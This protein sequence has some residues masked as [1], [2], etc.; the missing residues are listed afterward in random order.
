MASREL[1]KV[2]LVEDDED[3][4]VL[5]RDL[6]SEQDRTPC[7]LE[8]ATEA[9]QAL[10]LI[11]DGGH[12]VYLIDYRLGR[13]TGLDLV[14][15]A[16]DQYGRAPVI[17]LTGYDDYDVDLEAELLGVTDFLIKRPPRR[18]L[19]RALDPLRGSPSRGAAR[20]AREPGALRARRAR[21]QRRHLGLGP[22]AADTIYFAPRWK[23]MLGY[24]E[25]RDRRLAGGVVRP[26]P[27][28]G[29]RA[30]CGPTIAAH[31]DRHTPHFE[32]EHR[33]L[34]ADGTLPLGAAAAASRVRD[35]DGTADRV[36]AGSH[37]RHHRRARRP[38]SSS[39]TTRFHDA[40]TG[41]PN[42]A[43]FIDRLSQAISARG[44]TPSYSF[45]V[46]FLDLDRFKV[47]NDS[48][49]HAVGDQLL[50]ARRR[51]ACE[52]C[53]RARRHRRPPRRRRVHRPARRHAATP[54]T[55]C[56][57]PSASTSELQP[58]RS[59]S[60]GRRCSSTREHRHRA[61]QPG[62]E[63]PEDLLRDADIA[64]YRA[65]ATAA[66]RATRSS[67]SR[68]TRAPST[69]LQLE[70]DLRRASSASE[71]RVH[72]Q[73]IVALAT[74]RLAGF[75]ALVRWQ[76]PQRGAR[77]ARRL[78]PGRR[79]DRADRADRAAGCCAR[80][81]AQLARMAARASG[82]RGRHDQ[83][84]PLGAAVRAGRPRRATSRQA[85]GA[86]AGSRPQ[87][88]RLEITESVAHARRRGARSSATSTQL[89]RAR[90]PPRPRRLRHRLL[91]AQLP[92][93]LRRR[94]AQDRPLVRR[95]RS[96]ATTASAG[97]RPHD[98][99]PG[100]QPR[101]GVDRRGRR[102]R[103]PARRSCTSWARR[104][105]QGFLFARPLA[106]EGV[107]ELLATWEPER[108]AAAALN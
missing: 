45:A 31:L 107:E 12:D 79:G 81:A 4:Y 92:A 46:L 47:V 27:P 108:F 37:D 97:D 48:L 13:T 70:T 24:D 101:H 75:E 105:G 74:G 9:H 50:V 52:P 16:F 67:T 29:P 63:Q 66:R 15:E 87:A 65:K 68:C 57:S 44:A 10:R 100:Q 98:R 34:H 21:R 73:P 77:V 5:V 20:A 102:D 91:V 35:E 51:A 80:R 43:L 83:R 94:R 23:A 26:R 88:S 60:T 85:L 55:P 96:A 86:T 6:L 17:M 95:R 39:S 54:A 7:E 104:F 59:S 76:H 3:D 40:L 58:R 78:H 93:P 84:Q 71:F 82:R 25:R 106:P 18:P 72:Y 8:W 32:S 1:V 38:R 36:V 2:L 69:L 22:R 62:Y 19:T 89:Q 53:V 103:G 41:L 64:M 30:S 56:G 90:R 42:R 11:A 49:G 14:R 28:G 99:R 33:I 61:A